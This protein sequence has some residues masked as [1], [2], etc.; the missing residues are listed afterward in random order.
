MVGCNF[1]VFAL[2]LVTNLGK[3]DIG[4]TSARDHQEILTRKVYDALNKFMDPYVVYE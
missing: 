3:D 2:S 4:D 1:R